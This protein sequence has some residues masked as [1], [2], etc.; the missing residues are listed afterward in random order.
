MTDGVNTILET[1]DGQKSHSPPRTERYPSN[2]GDFSAA[3]GEWRVAGRV[4]SF[5][6][7]AGYTAAATGAGV[8]FVNAEIGMLEPHPSLS[9][10]S[11][12]LDMTPASYSTAPSD[13]SAFTYP[14][15]VPLART[16]RTRTYGPANPQNTPP[17][18]NSGPGYSASSY[19]HN[20]SSDS[21]PTP[22]GLAPGTT[23]QPN[24]PFFAVSLGTLPANSRS[25]APSLMHS[26]HHAPRSPRHSRSLS[27]L[28]STSLLR[29]NTAFTSTPSD[30][31]PAQPEFAR[32]IR[33]AQRGALH[34][35]AAT[36]TLAAPSPPI[37]RSPSPS[38][39]SSAPGFHSRN[40]PTLLREIPKPRFDDVNDRLGIPPDPSTST[41]ALSAHGIDSSTP[42]P[43]W[44]KY[45]TASKIRAQ[46]AAARSGEIP[47][48]TG[49][50]PKSNTAEF[51]NGLQRLLVSTGFKSATTSAAELDTVKPTLSSIGSGPSTPSTSSAFPAVT[52]FQT[53]YPVPSRSTPASALPPSLSSPPTYKPL[54]PSPTSKFA[55]LSQISA[56]T[57]EQL[58]REDD[59]EVRT[60]AGTRAK[61]R[62]KSKAV[63]VA[64][65]QEGWGDGEKLAY[66]SL[67]YLLVHLRR[68]ELSAKLQTYGWK[69]G[70]YPLPMAE[71]ATRR[72]STPGSAH[73]AGSW[74]SL[75]GVPEENE[76]TIATEVTTA[77]DLSDALPETDLDASAGSRSTQVFESLEKVNM[78]T[79]NAT[80]DNDLPPVLLDTETQS[81]EQRNNSGSLVDDHPLPPVPPN[82][83][84]Q[85]PLPVHPAEH[86]QSSPAFATSSSAPPILKRLPSLKQGPTKLSGADRRA[87]DVL[88]K[89]LEQYDSWAALLVKKIVAWIGIEERDTLLLPT[90]LEHQV[91][92]EDLAAALLREAGSRAQEVGNKSELSGVDDNDDLIAT[93]THVDLSEMTQ[94]EAKVGVGVEAVLQGRI[95]Q[96][97]GTTPS[98]LDDDG[99]TSATDESDVLPTTRHNR[100]WT[101]S[102][103]VAMALMGIEIQG[104]DEELR[105]PSTV[106]APHSEQETPKVESAEQCSTA[107]GFNETLYAFDPGDLSLPLE[108]VDENFNG[109]T[110]IS[111]GLMGPT[112]LGPEASNPVHRNN[113]PP[114]AYS[115]AP[116]ETIH[117]ATLSTPSVP[118]QLP[119]TRPASAVSPDSPATSLLSHLFLICIIDGLG[120]SARSRHLLRSF[121]SYVGV[122]DG[123]VTELEGALCEELSVLEEMGEVEWEV[124][125]AD[126]VSAP[127]TSPP[128]QIGV[129]EHPSGSKEDGRDM[130]A[131]APRTLALPTDL[132]ASRSQRAANRRLAFTT[133]AAIGGGVAVGL[134]AAAVAPMIGL[135]LTAIFGFMG[136]SGAATV[137]GGTT[138]MAIIGG[139]GAVVGGGSIGRKMRNRIAAVDDFIVISILPYQLVWGKKEA[140]EEEELWKKEKQQLEK[141]S[142]KKASPVRKVQPS[143]TDDSTQ[144]AKD[145]DDVDLATLA[146]VAKITPVI[147]HK[148][149][150]NPSENSLNAHMAGEVAQPPL[151]LLDG[152][153]PT[154]PPLVWHPRRHPAV[155]ICISGTLVVGESDY[156]KP[157]S[158]IQP[159][160]MG[161][162]Y[163]LQWDPETLRNLGNAFTMLASEV[164]SF[165]VSQ[166][167]NVTVLSILMNGLT[168]PQT[169]LK[170]GYLVDNPWAR[171][172]EKGKKA[173][174]LMAD[175]LI[176]RAQGGR[177]VT[178]IGSSIG[179]R[180]IFYCL[181][182]LAERGHFDLVEDAFIFG[183]PVVATRHEWERCRAAVC[184]RF[185]N[186]F[187]EEDWILGLLYRSASLIRLRN[188][189]GLCPILDVPLIE[190]VDLSDIVSSH[191][192]YRTRTPRILKHLGIPVWREWFDRED[193]SEYQEMI[194]SAA[195]SP[196]SPETPI[197]M[198][199]HG[200][201]S[202]T[203]EAKQKK[204]LDRAKHAVMEGKG[205]DS[206][207]GA[208]GLLSSVWNAEDIAE[209]EALKKIDLSHWKPR[210]LRSTMPALKIPSV[211]GRKSDW[212]GA[213]TSRSYERLTDYDDSRAGTSDVPL[214]RITEKD[215][216]DIRGSEDSPVLIFGNTLSEVV[217]SRLNI[218]GDLDDVALD[219]NVGEPIV[220]PLTGRV[221]KKRIVGIGPHGFDAQG[222][223]APGRSSSDSGGKGRPT[224]LRRTTSRT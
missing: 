13:P 181:L 189:A 31:E 68:R 151:R 220:D 20:N 51:V 105:P 44:P 150:R 131:L 195:L 123:E 145:D 158:L 170:L 185:V 39:V 122:K 45:L 11:K 180:V 85:A 48:V 79:T 210:E 193:E 143:L 5:R 92:P 214:D 46:V 201:K 30:S 167:L 27:G 212:Q 109:S 8:E 129:S 127:E 58:V 3:N 53:P 196:T 128:S 172:L 132:V 73:G 110:G 206:A 40:L 29:S 178:L 137:L 112:A 18:V 19:P 179:G 138:G 57:L 164:I 130:D 9:S 215:R 71:T 115:S 65:L 219:E 113:T 160:A 199:G 78:E 136:V 1:A 98:R 213:A 141:E 84:L 211:H 153:T 52:P 16:R 144:V 41:G 54:P 80:H 35:G 111:L 64:E 14:L 223:R 97:K 17:P 28:P 205:K 47:G 162:L 50:K 159:G 133:M 142:K 198:R 204:V 117:G 77:T 100:K 126:A 96:D 217:R 61:R 104:D 25:T 38:V 209:F 156:T 99:D 56:A 6:A 203:D 120:Y 101:K 114:P 184:G 216:R 119:L 218:E 221:T 107:N 149:S 182:E 43:S 4:G 124:Q 190:N 69:E 67:I 147:E 175:A 72:Q 10:S 91:R 108:T 82:V 202:D 95:G 87:R 106:V 161:E 121:A 157:W 89:A 118:S 36:F 169:V 155:T 166:I 103:R 191:L 148:H 22:P 174:L 83:D 140:E 86:I 59:A 2:K 55:P 37:S 146:N 12:P 33:T 168:L 75:N 192:E 23:P 76:R 163:A 74:I 183:S 66:L 222:S 24:A 187:I 135:G 60:D 134:T 42:T 177:P 200:S 208:D 102:E 81:S 26:P 88:R 49:R 154:A 176:A 173:G 224:K 15:P 171:A 188:I 63:K 62:G 197:S 93:Q 94:D 125:S 186:G 207:V 21:L 139:A 194:A 90:L 34:S 7:E 32:H 116:P 152:F 70:F 165:G